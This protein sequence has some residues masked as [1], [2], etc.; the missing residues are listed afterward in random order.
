MTIKKIKIQE[1][2]INAAQTA[3]YVTDLRTASKVDSGLIFYAGFM[4]ASMLSYVA[5]IKSIASGPRH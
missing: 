5:N 1:I 2:A 4:L 3:A